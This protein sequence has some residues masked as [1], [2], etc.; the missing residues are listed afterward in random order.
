MW[1]HNLEQRPLFDFSDGGQYKGPIVLYYYVAVLKTRMLFI[2][3]NRNKYWKLH[4]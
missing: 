2:K 1:R 4:K 3:F